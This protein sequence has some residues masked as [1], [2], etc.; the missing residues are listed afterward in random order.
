MTRITITHQDIDPTTLAMHLE[1]AKHDPDGQV[2]PWR[3]LYPLAGQTVYAAPIVNGRPLGLL[4]VVVARAP[5]PV[6]GWPTPSTPP[7]DLVRLVAE[8]N[9]DIQCTAC[10]DELRPVTWTAQDEDNLHVREVT[11]SLVTEV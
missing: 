6:P 5:S 9:R 11:A 8:G 7:S 10:R 1:S 2:Y 3:D 4:W